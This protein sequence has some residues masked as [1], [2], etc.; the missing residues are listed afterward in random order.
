LLVPTTLPD[1]QP[2][3]TLVQV[4]VPTIEPASVPADGPPLAGALPDWACW[5]DTLDHRY[6][7]GVE[8]EIM[9]LDPL[10]WSLAQA[11]DIVLARV[12]EALRRRTAAETHAGVVEVM[13]GVHDDV[14]GVTGELLALRS[15]LAGELHSMRLSAAAAGTHPM[16]VWHETEIS[17]PPRYRDLGDSM[18]V[19]AHREPTMALHVHVGIPDPEEA[20]KVYAA[21]R[22]QAPVLLALSAN[23]PFWQERDTGF[24]SARTTIFQAFP[25]TGTPPAAARYADYVTAVQ[26]LIASG[27]LRDPSFLWW[28]VR[29]QP[30]LG[31]VEVRVMD[32]QSSVRQVGPLVALV[33]SVA[34]LALEEGLPQ[35]VHGDEVLAENRF[36]AARDGTAARFI[37]PD[38]ERL[39]PVREIV[40]DLVSACQP[41]ALALGCLGA[42][43]RVRLLSSANGADRQRVLAERDGRLEHVV[44]S[45]AGQFQAGRYTRFG[46]PLNSFDAYRSTTERGG[47]CAAGSHTQD[48]LC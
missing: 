23:S 11:S 20:T 39:I 32:A 22:Q 10:R 5:N 33:Q 46:K 12:S 19:L 4:S 34:R 15:Q 38:A 40:D 1:S 36:L 21:L 2:V 16:T 3:T 24:A 9:L 27:A 28:D 41:H 45:L 47:S 29:L 18:R 8:E 35:A 30:R 26:P 43:N 42:L 31:T 13:T 6:T 44:A 25:R 7:I 17:G 48:H 37:D 14:F